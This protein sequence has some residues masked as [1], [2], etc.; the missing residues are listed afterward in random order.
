MKVDANEGFFKQKL[1]KFFATQSHQ[2]NSAITDEYS[3]QA[4]PTRFNISA[5]QTQLTTVEC[6]NITQ[7]LS[8]KI[9]QLDAVATAKP[10]L[11]Q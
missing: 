8:V 9:N 2:K 6:A 3:A 7:I 5:K 10:L 11:C 4:V 1:I